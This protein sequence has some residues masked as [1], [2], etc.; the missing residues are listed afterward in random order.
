MDTKQQRTELTRA[1]ATSSHDFLEL[2]P[3]GDKQKFILSL[4]SVEHNW[5]RRHVRKECC[6]SVH[7]YI[8]YQVALCDRTMQRLATW[9]TDKSSL[10]F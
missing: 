7:V 5:I 6:R 3:I 1:G 4:F 8:W 10:S 9:D 2:F